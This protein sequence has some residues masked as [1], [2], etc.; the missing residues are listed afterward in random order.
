MVVP[1]VVDGGIQAMRDELRQRIV[2]ELARLLSRHIS[3]ELADVAR[4]FA[5]LAEFIS[6]GWAR[7]PQD[8]IVTQRWVS[9]ITNVRHQVD[10]GSDFFAAQFESLFASM[11]STFIMTGVNTNW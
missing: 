5:D 6:C 7:S 2:P 4:A 8:L 1:L 9:A 3:G 10:R 11:T